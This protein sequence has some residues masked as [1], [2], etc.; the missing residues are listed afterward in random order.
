MAPFLDKESVALGMK[1][2]R[3]SEG[4]RVV[5]GVTLG[6]LCGAAVA[7]LFFTDRGRELRD[8]IEPAVDDLREEFARFLKTIE[9]VRDLANDGMR[10]MEEC[11]AARAQ[12]PGPTGATSH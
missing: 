10:V 12:S 6:A 4:S 2:G 7:Y 3:V 11:R 9:K 8:R 1:G 5:L